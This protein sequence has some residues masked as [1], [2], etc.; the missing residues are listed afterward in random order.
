MALKFN[1]KNLSTDAV[2]AAKADFGGGFYTGPVP[3]A[4]MYNVKVGALW[5]KEISN[6]D[7]QIVAR[8]VINE[9]GENATYNG[10]TTFHR[11]TIPTDSTDQYFSIRLK[12]LDD[13]FRAISGGTM[14]V[15]EFVEAAKANRIK[16]G[17]TEK[18]GD[19]IEQIGKFKV[20][21]A[22]EIRI[23]SKVGTYRNEPTFETHWVDTRNVGRP[24]V[25]QS[26]DF[27][28]DVEGLDDVQDIDSEIDDLLG[29]DEA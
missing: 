6:G 8:L 4:G 25:D 1:L 10:A 22:S 15:S 9:T 16:I 27:D 20:E 2:E 14:G 5:A 23:K 11:M 28:D 26:S 7:S 3:P 12:S 24:G 17:K 21:N 18:V 19:P 13:F 29:E